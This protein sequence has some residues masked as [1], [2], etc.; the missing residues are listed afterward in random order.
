M[1]WR[2]YNIGASHCFFIAIGTVVR[3]MEVEAVRV[4]WGVGELY[5]EYI[6]AYGV[7]CRP[8]ATQQ[9]HRTTREGQKR[10]LDV[11]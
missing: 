7:C 9:S 11:Q 3:R 10:R 5:T 2:H 4:E 8:F 1:V 6:S